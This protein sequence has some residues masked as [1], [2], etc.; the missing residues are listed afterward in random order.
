MAVVVLALLTVCASVSLLPVKL[1]SPA[2]VAVN[3][4]APP[5]PSVRLQLPDA[6][7]PVQ[8]AA[9]R[10]SVTVTLPVGVPLLEV[11]V[12]L[13][14]TAWLRAD[15]SG[16]SPVMVVVVLAL[17]TECDSVSLLPAKLVLPAYVAVRVRAPAVLNVMLQLPDAT[18]P[19]QLAALA[20]SVTETFPLGVPPA[21]VTVKV[22]VTGW[23]SADASGAS[24]VIVVVVV[25]WFTVWASVSLLLAKLASPA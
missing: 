10:L 15:A 18:V 25:A 21:E 4:W 17:L 5:V 24:P 11:T 6:T 22:T 13:T 8:L 16:E 2:Y 3:V 9:L 19:V 12:K 7:V 14:V 23:L 20:L 1:V